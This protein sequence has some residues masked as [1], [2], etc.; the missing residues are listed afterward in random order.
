MFGKITSLSLK[1][2]LRSPAFSQNIGTTLM[3]A[4]MGLYLGLTSIALGAVGP[5]IADEL[6]EQGNPA[7]I[8]GKYFLYTLIYLFLGRLVFQNFGFKSLKKYILQPIKKSKIYHYILSKTI[9]HWINTI[10]LLGIAAYLIASSIAPE[11]NIDVLNHGLVMIGL[12]YFTNFTAFLVDKYLNINKI[13]TGGIILLIVILNFLDIRGIIPLGKVLETVFLAL[14]ANIGMA[15]LPISGAAIAYFACHN[16]LKKVAYLEDDV[17]DSAITEVNIRPGLFS[18]FGRAGEMMEMEL[19]LI[20]RNKRSRNMMYV[21][22]MIFLYPLISHIEESYNSMGWYMFVAI[23]TTGGFALTYGQLLLSWNSGHF[24]LLLTKMT[25]IK[26]IFQAK[27]Y[28]QCAIIIVQTMILIFYGF[29]RSEYFLLMPAMMFYNLGFVLFL[30]MLLASYNSKK[31]DTNKG[32]AMNYEGFSMSLFLIIIP[33]MV[34]PIVLYH[35]FKFMG[36]PDMGI[37]LTALIGLI[38]F[39]FHDKLIDISVNLFK[40]NRHKIG[41]AFRTK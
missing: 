11:Y 27:Y 4:L 10:T 32:A 30:Y 36:Y 3:M 38:G 7:G 6:S 37:Y 21:I 25:S 26:E 14:T 18:R 9:F 24:D 2:F 35:G 33:I 28:L 20:F 5:F 16:V 31:I 40:K 34:V 22:V 8:L 17:S 1:S 23:F 19:K 13:V 12:L 39:V 41:T 15:S 29:F